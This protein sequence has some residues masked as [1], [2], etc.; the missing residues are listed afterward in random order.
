MW[1]Q[2][3]AG[4]N[5]QG[6]GEAAGV[7]PWMEGKHPAHAW[8]LNVWLPEP[9]NKFLFWQSLICGRV[10][11]SPGTP[12]HHVGEEGSGLSDLD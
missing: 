7:V 5:L 1:P 12:I 11:V 10:M 3:Q 2:A 4:D 8:I 9:E 6:L